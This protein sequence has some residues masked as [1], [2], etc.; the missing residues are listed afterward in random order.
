MPIQYILE[1]LSIN[2]IDCKVEGSTVAFSFAPTMFSEAF[3]IENMSVFED[4]VICQ[5]SFTKKDFC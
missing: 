2:I 3:A 4:L 5:I 1:I